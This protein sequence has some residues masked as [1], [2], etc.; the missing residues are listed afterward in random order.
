[1]ADKEAAPALKEIFNPQRIRHIA[2]EASLVSPAFDR[3]L[4][5]ARCSDFDQGSLMARMGRVAESLHAAL[6]GDYAAN[7]AVLREL[8]PRLNSSFV[9]L[10][11]PD[12]VAR[13][14]AG[15]FETSMDALKF[16]TTFGSSEF[17]VR[18]F[19]QRDFAR[20]LAVMETWA[21]D[22][23]EHVRRL[24]SE[25]SR[26]R[27]PWSFQIKPLMRDPSPLEPIL[28]A[29]KDD[30]SLYVRRSVA[31]SLND[32]TK[33]NPAWALDR[34]E[35]WPLEKT[36]TAWIAKH[37]LRS[38]IKKGDRRA[39]TII[40]AGAVPRV[41]LT[42][43][44]V[45][46]AAIT[47]GQTIDIAFELSSLADE[48]QR[49]VVDYAIHYVKKSGGV[50][51]KVFKL[52][53]LELAEGAVEQVRKRQSIANFTTRI[54]YPGRHDIEILINGQVHGRASFELLPD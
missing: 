13:H 10:I 50:A 26:P 47:L 27:L 15:H 33:D 37:A 24:A 52:K 25:G 44:R 4:F 2:D 45:S 28:N 35:R 16:F 54:H 39:L 17:A 1:M 48:S 7:I 51:A 40:G 18:H 6:P 42:G 41:A 8:A 49:L 23:N 19:L 36:G 31:N 38:L 46:P 12:Y 9:T 29:L 14:G 21:H 43:L 34:I 53:T 30:P 5:L 32:I 20:T 11:L 22:E 3:A